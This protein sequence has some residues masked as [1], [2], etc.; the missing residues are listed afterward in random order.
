MIRLKIEYARQIVLR[1]KEILIGIAR[2]AR[3][4]VGISPVGLECERIAQRRDRCSEITTLVG[5]R[6]A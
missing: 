5:I 3:E 6:A 1:I 4:E 2:E